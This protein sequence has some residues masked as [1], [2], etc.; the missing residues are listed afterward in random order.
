MP[1]IL[2]FT[3]IQDAVSAGFQVYDKTSEGYLVRTRTS[4]GWAL[5]VVVIRSEKSF[6]S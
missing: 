4:A 1:G 5:A 3:S 2:T 6:H